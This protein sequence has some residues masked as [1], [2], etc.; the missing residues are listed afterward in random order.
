MLRGALVRRDPRL[1]KAPAGLAEEIEG[2]VW[3]PGAD[4][5]PQKEA[6]VDK[7]N[8]SLDT[9]RYM[10]AELDLGTSQGLF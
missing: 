7:D 9:A 1:G 4:G 3:A 2:Y 6:P 5:K 10:V 8:H